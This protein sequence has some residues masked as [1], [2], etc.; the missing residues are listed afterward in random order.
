MSNETKI[1]IET[2]L[3]Q[4]EVTNVIEEVV[5]LLPEGDTEHTALHH[6]VESYNLKFGTNFK[7]VLAG[8]L[9]FPIDR[10]QFYLN[11]LKEL[12]G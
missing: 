4:Y 3:Q 1:A 12:K 6:F 7:L 11:Q 9:N 5:E 8:Q 2:G 10:I